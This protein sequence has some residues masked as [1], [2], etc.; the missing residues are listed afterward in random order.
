[1]NTFNPHNIYFAKEEARIKRHSDPALVGSRILRMTP[2][3]PDLVG[4]P[5][6]LSRLWAECVNI[7]GYHSYVKVLINFEFT[8]KI[9]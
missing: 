2:N 7:K 8:K 9:I 1:M 6:P 3:D 4:L 5:L